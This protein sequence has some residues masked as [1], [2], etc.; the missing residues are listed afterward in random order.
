MVPSVNGE[1]VINIKLRMVWLKFADRT[2]REG[3]D[4]ATH[5]RYRISPKTCATANRH[6]QW[7]HQVD[8]MYQLQHP[9]VILISFRLVVARYSTSQCFVDGYVGISTI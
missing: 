6:I 1:L 4:S 5:L 7:Q 3:I 9:V 2:A 8:D